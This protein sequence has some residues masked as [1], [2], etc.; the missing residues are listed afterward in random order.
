MLRLRLLGGAEVEGEGV[1][2]GGAAAQRRPLAVLGLLAASGDRGMS[3][4]KIL[5]YLWPEIPLE[6]AAHRLAQILYALRRE[7]GAPD[8]FLGTSDLRLN[9]ERMTS[10]MREFEA[11]LRAGELERAVDLFGGPFLDGF[12]LGDAPEFE[13]WVENERAGL[14]RRLVETL[15]ALAARATAAGDQR[16]AADWW[17][18]LAELDPLSSRITVHLMSALAAAGSR[19]EA[20]QRA[21]AYGVLVQQELEAA[22]S[23]V[24]VALAD[25]M[26]RD[27][28]PH[29]SVGVLPF[30]KLT[31]LDG[32]GEFVE[33]L[34]E[35]IRSRLAAIAYLKVSARFSVH[36]LAQAGLEAEEIGWK[37][38][39]DAVLE[40]SV[41][42]AG[43]RVRVSVRLI[44]A[45]DG[46]HR[47]SATYEREVTDAF[48]AEDE[49]GAAIAAEVGR[50]LVDSP[51]G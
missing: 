14:A 21:E 36:E 40:G 17:R 29:A 46:C 19:R 9:P 10:D 50:V 6:K 35:E 18:R 30:V 1:P 8:L 34:T 42:Q 15:E 13:H 41:R 49:L 51:H 37:L 25:Q 22:P 2:L 11:S 48:D 24:V 3:R 5:A 44:G 38:R 4:D 27:P 33:G 47:W 12:F 26:R 39:L 32:D 28:R 7:F 31:P 20:I 16:Q 43:H 45:G 23:P